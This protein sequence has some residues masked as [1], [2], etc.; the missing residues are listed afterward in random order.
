MPDDD[1]AP[2]PRLI[3]EDLVKIVQ[4]GAED[5]AESSLRLA[6]LVRTLNDMTISVP[7]DA[8]VFIDRMS[9]LSLGE[10]DARALADCSA[11]F[12]V[13]VTSAS[14][15]VSVFASRSAEA[16]QQA[17]DAFDSASGSVDAL[18]AGDIG[19]QDWTLRSVGIAD[20]MKLLTAQNQRLVAEVMDSA[21]TFLES[22][23]E[24]EKLF[25]ACLKHQNP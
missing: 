2:F 14:G 13:Q 6:L 20:H 8:Q 22:T 3:S 7:R 17:R 18:L 11:R 5:V 9:T 21:D 19:L 1:Y 23:C 15:A 25:F 12:S 16:A 24:L 4:D 10:A